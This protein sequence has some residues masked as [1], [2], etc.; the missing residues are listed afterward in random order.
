[1]EVAA[2]E[3]MLGT[4]IPLARAM[5]VRI[6]ECA[7]ACVIITAPLAL[8]R[9]HLGT[10]FGGSLH[11]LATLAGYGLVWTLIN[12]PAAHV[13]IRESHVRYEHPVRGELRAVC[14]A[15][16]EAKTAQFLRQFRRKGKARVSLRS[17]I[18]ENGIT[19]VEFNGIFVARR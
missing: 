17:T 10:A 4:K 6:V 16:A 3:E 11:A 2:L 14:L 7:P 15:P 1:M 5:G 19:A 9:N 18:E 13:V 12:D 8:N